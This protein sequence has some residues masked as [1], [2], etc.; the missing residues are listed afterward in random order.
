MLEWV[1]G[2]SVL[3]ETLHHA[4]GL[5]MAG[6]ESALGEV[7]GI[8][9]KAAASVAAID[10]KGLRQ[11]RMQTGAAFLTGIVLYSGSH[12]LPFGDILWAIPLVR[13]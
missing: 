1:S 13:L 3:A 12:A 8:E 4:A 7:I 11:L 6:L 2:A 5:R 10:F 9:V